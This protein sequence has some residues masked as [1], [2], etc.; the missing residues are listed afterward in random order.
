M[1]VELRDY[2]EGTQKFQLEKTER[3]EKHQ[4]VTEK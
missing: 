2:G 3:T 1:A 4:Q